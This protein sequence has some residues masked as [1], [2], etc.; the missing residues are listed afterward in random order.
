LKHFHWIFLKINFTLFLPMVCWNKIFFIIFLLFSIKSF[1]YT[2][3]EGKVTAAV[4]P[5]FYKTYFLGTEPNADS[6]Y[7]GGLGLI[8]L[9]DV[10]DT[11]SLEIN[12]YFMRKLYIYTQDGGNFAEKTQQVQIGMGYHFWLS[13]YFS[14]ALTLYSAYPIGEP[15]IVHNDFPQGSQETTSAENKTNYGLDF[16]IQA[17][18]WSNDKFSVELAGDYALALPHKNSEHADHYGIFLGLR[19]LVQEKNPSKKEKN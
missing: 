9:G 11:G 12:A 15:E 1:A 10:N 2:A 4:G 13:H 6:P 3:E 5:Y 7:L 18:L 8:A 16:S 17:D 19:Y 14:T